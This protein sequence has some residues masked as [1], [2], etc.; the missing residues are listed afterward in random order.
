MRLAHPF[1]ERLYNDAAHPR[2]S[3]RRPFVAAPSSVDAPSTASLTEY[4]LMVGRIAHSF[5]EADNVML[6]WQTI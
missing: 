1:I 2:L 6:D 4:V 3:A 5:G